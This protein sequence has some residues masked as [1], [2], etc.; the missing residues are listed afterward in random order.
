MFNGLAVI[1]AG[2]DLDI[3]RSIVRYF[4]GIIAGTCAL[5]RLRRG[6]TDSALVRWRH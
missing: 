5:L 3:D 4:D 1:K 6:V 2:G